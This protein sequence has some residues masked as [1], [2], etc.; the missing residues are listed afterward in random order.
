MQAFILVKVSPEFSRE[1]NKEILGIKG[2]TEVYELTGDV[3]LLLRVQAVD[4]E[5]L[6]KIVFRVRETPGIQETDTRMVI[7]S[8][9]A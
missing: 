5:E 9:R 2:V 7:S 4:V 3:D 8:Y 1:A 6:S